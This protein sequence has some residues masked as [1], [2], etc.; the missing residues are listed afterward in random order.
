MYGGIV[1]LVAA[2]GRKS[3]LL[4]FLRWDADVCRAVEPGTLRFDVWESPN[5]PNVV[6]LYEAY[7][8]QDAFEAHKVNEPFRK[9][10][11]EIVPSLFEP[12]TF[13]LPFTNS[14]MSN[15]GG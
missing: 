12:P 7:A 8:D 5:D 1:R 10:V 3:E 9:F 11:D 2:E 4:N 13:V 6:Y 15:S 14:Y